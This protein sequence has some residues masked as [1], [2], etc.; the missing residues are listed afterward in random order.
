MDWDGSFRGWAPGALLA[1]LLCWPVGGAAQEAVVLSGGGARGLAHAGALVGLDRLGHDPAIVTGTSMGAVVGSLYAAGYEPAEIWR[2]IERQDWLEIFAPRPLPAGPERRARYPVLA[3]GPGVSGTASSPGLIPDWRINRLLGRLLFDAD[4]RALSDFDSLPRRFRA[5]AA[6]LQTGAAAVLAGG[7][8]ARAV[9]ASMAV[10]GFFGPVVQQDRVLVDG[11]VA[12]YLPVGPAWELG[13]DRVIAVDVSRP[14][15]ELQGTGPLLVASRAVDLLEL[16]ARPPAAPPDVLVLPHIDPAVTAANFPV[17]PLPLL[18]EGLDAVL[19]DVPPA[20]GM[21]APGRRPAR[22]PPARLA[23]LLVT[24]PT[25][26]LRA[27]VRRA[28]EGV[29]PGPYDPAAVLAAVDR[30]YATGLFDAVWPS[31]APDSTSD[32][33][34]HVVVRPRPNPLLGGAVTYDNDRGGRAWVTARLL[35]PLAGRAAEVSL[36]GSVDKLERWLSA[37][38]RMPLAERTVIDFS[39]D[40]YI[41]EQQLRGVPLDS[42]RTEA[43]RVRRAGGSIGAGLR[44]S[45]LGTS[46]LLLLG[47]EASAAAAGPDGLAVGPLL[48]VGAE[49]RFTSI[50]GVAPEVEGEIRLGGGGY[51]RVLARGSLDGRL[52]RMMVAAEGLAELANR[53]APFHVLPA[54]GNGHAVPGFLVGEARGQGR[55]VA[56]GEV[57]L[58]I[59]GITT[60]RVRLLGATLLH[61][62]DPGFEGSG[63]GMDV[64]AVWQTPLGRALAG[65]GANTWGFSRLEVSVGPAF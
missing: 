58:P 37:S 45:P 11:G 7:D 15:P 43:V 3:F 60:L 47:A 4:A 13:A 57:A 55:L 25:P 56:G 23:H 21:T 17:D 54:L 18:R 1:L 16:K 33:L 49:P 65:F 34:L 22:S 8:L 29:V 10:P 42:E 27:L 51:R 32:P 53:S 9:R 31:V 40:G 35:S 28:F 14:S 52:G 41:S 38:A 30:L 48:R 50:I 5:V 59:P 39:L 24:A 2:L 63:A 46:A 36:T 61:P 26:A 12:D 62:L 44:R 19:A 6:D 20:T 64:A